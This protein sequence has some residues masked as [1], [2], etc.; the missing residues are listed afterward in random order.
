[1]GSS[2]K[3]KSDIKFVHE[4]GDPM[5]PPDDSPKKKGKKRGAAKEASPESDSSPQEGKRGSRNGGKRSV[6][7]T[8]FESPKGKKKELFERKKAQ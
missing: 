3:R 5:S 4:N 7:Y 1:M 8:D 6:S 2:S